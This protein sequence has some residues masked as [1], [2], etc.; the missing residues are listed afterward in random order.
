MTDLVQPRRAMQATLLGNA[1]L[2]SSVLLAMTV[3]ATDGHEPLLIGG[4]LVLVAAIW[5]IGPVGYALKHKAGSRVVLH[6]PFGVVD[7]DLR[8]GFT[9]SEAR[10]GGGGLVLRANGKRYRLVKSIGPASLVDE[11]LRRVQL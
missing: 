11:W 7:I 1:V 10:R 5:A 3:A 4:G 2:F 8:D 9:V 6:R